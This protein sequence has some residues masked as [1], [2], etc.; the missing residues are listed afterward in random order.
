MSQEAHVAFINERLNDHNDRIID[1]GVELTEIES[2]S[3]VV[4]GVNRVGDVIARELEP[5]GFTATRTSIGQDRGQALLL[6]KQLRDEGLRVLILGHADT[7]W[8]EGTGAQWPV[9]RTSDKID[10]PGFG[11]MKCALAMAVAAV[12]TVADQELPGIASLSFALVPDEELG[13]VGSREWLLELG[14]HTDVCLTLEAGLDGGGFITSRG[15]VGAMILTAHGRTAH[16]TEGTG[17]SAV[18]ALAPLVEPLEELTVREERKMVTVGILRGGTA[19]QVVPDHCELHLDL[20]APDNDV[21][22][23]I[24]REVHAQATRRESDG[25]RIDISGGVTR[26][27]L[28]QTK[29]DPIYDR[30][31]RYSQEFSLPA[32]RV[33]ETGGSDASIVCVNAPYFLDGLGPIAYKQCS[34]EEWVDPKTILPRTKVLAALLLDLGDAPR[35]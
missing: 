30:A 3:F 29:S 28:A 31:A 33:A 27:A 18:A 12:Q 24:V 8:P 7:V 1:L 5:H 2:G 26:P 9:T 13:S 11:D 34:R 17:V 16:S 4:D 23:G 22:D 35:V 6:T 10:G 15:A 32:Y 14:E 25:L 20:R 21:A 19:R